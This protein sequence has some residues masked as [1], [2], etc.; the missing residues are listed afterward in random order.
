MRAW[1]CD[2]GGTVVL[3][4]LLH[5]FTSDEQAR[6][7]AAAA[8]HATTVIIRD[9]VRDGSWRYRMTYAQEMFSR[10]GA[11]ASCGAAALRDARR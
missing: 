1:R 2:R 9:A 5:Y 10:V 8:A 3:L 11:L 4:D 6:I 7:L